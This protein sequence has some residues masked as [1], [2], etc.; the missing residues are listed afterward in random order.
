[1]GAKWRIDGYHLMRKFER[2]ELEE[3]KNGA[4]EVS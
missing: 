4:G 2:K 1:M 3:L